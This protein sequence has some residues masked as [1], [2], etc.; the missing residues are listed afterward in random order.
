MKK[1]YQTRVKQ[2]LAF[3]ESLEFIDEFDGNK[4]KQMIDYTVHTVAV[5]IPSGFTS[6]ILKK[7][8]NF[9]LWVAKPP[10]IMIVC[11]V[12]HSLPLLLSTYQP[13]SSYALAL[14]LSLSHTHTYIQP[15]FSSKMEPQIF[16]GNYDLVEEFIRERR[17]RYHGS[18]L[19]LKPKII[20]QSIVGGGGGG[21]SQTMTCQNNMSRNSSSK[22]HNRKGK[23][24]FMLWCCTWSSSGSDGVTSSTG[25]GT[26]PKSH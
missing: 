14:S 22:C 20:N 18:S 6:K 13:T 24:P 25:K 8:I 9:F 10:V 23:N 7:L 4:K 5:V 15:Y 1:N 16:E 19:A 17:K 26:P 12:F 21:D 11:F 3:C 2:L